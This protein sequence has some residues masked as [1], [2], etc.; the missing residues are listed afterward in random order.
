[1]CSLCAGRRD[2]ATVS[3]GAQGNTHGET[4]RHHRHI[5]H[6]LSFVT[7]AHQVRGKRDRQQGRWTRESPQAVESL[8]SRKPIGSESPR[9][10]TC[11][12]V[13]SS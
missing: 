12:A 9:A 3:G 5:M 7:P 2:Y 13:S 10:W 1:M 11:W 8:N 4:D 6:A